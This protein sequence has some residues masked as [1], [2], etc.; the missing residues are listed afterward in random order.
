MF[1]M[2][3]H[4]TNKLNFKEILIYD[5]IFSSDDTEKNSP[6]PNKSKKFSKLDKQ[7][8]VHDERFL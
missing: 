6:S 3:Y 4:I 5:S 2:F 1:I 8:I 7:I